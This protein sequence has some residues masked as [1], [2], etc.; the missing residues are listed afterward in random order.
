MTGIEKQYEYD[1][2]NKTT[3]MRFPY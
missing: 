2:V 3:Q 1:N